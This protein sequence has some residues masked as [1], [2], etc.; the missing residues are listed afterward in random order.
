MKRLL[1]VLSI[2]LLASGAGKKPKL[3]DRVVQ[4]EQALGEL[5]AAHDHDDAVLQVLWDRTLD[6][7][8]RLEKLEG[9][10]KARFRAGN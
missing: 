9:T 7:N 5:Q 2:G 4:L 8:E 3:E 10:N 1:L 6:L